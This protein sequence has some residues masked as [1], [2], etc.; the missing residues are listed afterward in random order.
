MVASVDVVSEEQII[1]RLDITILIR[2]PPKIK[3]SHQILVLAVDISEHL[4]GCIYPG[5]HWLR[6]Q[7]LLSL[8]REGQDVFSSEG[9]V[10]LTVDGG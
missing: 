3:E 2:R 6:L 10:G 4:D 9:E 8:F 7:D 1:I 5:H